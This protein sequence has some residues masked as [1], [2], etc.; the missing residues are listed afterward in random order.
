MV[1]P[2]ARREFLAASAGAAAPD[3]F[4]PRVGLVG[5]GGRGTGLLRTL[6]ALDIAAV[7]AICDINAQNLE[8]ARDAV[9]KAG[10]PAPEGYGRHEQDYE[11]LMAREDLDAVLIA[12]P[13]EW[14]A[15]MAAHG[16]R[17]GKYVAVEV[18]AAITV[19]ECWQLVDTSEQTGMPC[20]MLENWSF[21]RPNLA[22]LNMIR[23]GLLGE[24]VH[25]HCAHSHNCIYWYF[26]KE[27]NP[28]WSGEHL[29]RRN[30]DPYP[31]HSLGPV[32]SWMDI[33]CG[34]CFAQLTSTASRSLGIN[35]DFR[36]KFGS[37]HP[38][39]SRRY[40]QGDI[41]TS[42]V[43]TARGNTIVINNDM[44]LPR[45]YDNRWMIQGAEGLYDEARN[46]V[47][48]AGRSPEYEKW[49]PFPPYQDK[50]DH[51][52]WKALAVG[53]PDFGHGGTDYLELSL[54]IEAVRRGGPAPIDVYDSVTMSVII[55]LSEQSIAQ[56]SAPVACPDFT[57]G[58][59]KTRKPSF[60]LEG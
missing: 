45:P 30:A 10:H 49:E 23:L 28:R 37:K 24:I 57:R 20:M 39:A 58:R 7:P 8:Q 46:A 44:Q 40:R 59:W 11:R 54:F 48:I 5:S 41:V 2:I 29:L 56:G 9:R 4:L 6:L 31:T 32:L 55:P 38:A 15:R 53:S 13:W 60:A 52:W 16:M 36:K 19:E 12:T 3:R 33:N 27:G 21:L 1:K 51:S 18:P 22:L 34:D 14:H 42:V 43:K 50:Y 25:C 47:Y 17:A 26:D 35:N